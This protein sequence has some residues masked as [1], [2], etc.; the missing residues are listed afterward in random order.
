MTVARTLLVGVVLS[1]AACAPKL[2]LRHKT[3][4]LAQPWTD[5][6]P[7]LL[8]TGVSD[9]SGGYRWGMMGG[10]IGHA[11]F[12]RPLE[13]SVREA[14][15]GE[16]QALGVTLASTPEQAD[17]RLSVSISKIESIWGVGYGV[18]V[19]SFIELV[20]SFRD[21]AGKAVLWDAPV[22]GTGHE[23]IFVSSK[24]GG[25]PERTLSVAL[26]AAMARMRELFLSGDVT[27]RL[28]AGAAEAVVAAPV[29]EVRSDVDTVPTPAGVTPRRAHAVVVG[30]ERYRAALPAADFA[31]SDARLFGRY[32]VETLGFP[33]ENVAVLVN[34]GAAKSD[35]EKFFEKW[36]AN[37]VEKDDEVFVYFSGHGAPDPS[38]G[39]SY[40]VPYDGDPTYLDQTAY[41]LKKLY[42]SLGALPAKQVTVVLDSCF[43]GAGGRSVLAKGARP[44]V[45]ARADAA[46]PANVTVMAAAAGNQISNTFHAKGHGLFTYFML[47][48]LS[49]QAGRPVVDW[50]GVFTDARKNVKDVARKEY[51]LDQEPQMREGR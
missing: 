14:V 8:V 44:L 2:T 7:S 1:S 43:S 42:A 29:A 31:A 24:P 3:E 46:L 32:L 22:S 9:R 16:L 23:R 34:Q 26:G 47:K 17:A 50:E 48:G 6:K 41:P 21:R 28:G 18:K 4:P 27:A 51:N 40:L 33:K 37:R 45:S 20:L 10:V 5:A 25:A 13:D 36:L 39:D 35:F 11:T 30:V 19:N 49:E 15:A 38:N 12:A